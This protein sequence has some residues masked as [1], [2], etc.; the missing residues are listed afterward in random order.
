MNESPSLKDDHKEDDFKSILNMYKAIEFYIFYL[1]VGFFAFGLAIRGNKL[2]NAHLE[3]LGIVGGVFYYMRKCET[4]DYRGMIHDTFTECW[5]E[6]MIPVFLFSMAQ[7]L[8][9]TSGGMD[10]GVDEDNL[11]KQPLE[12]RKDL[13]E[14]ETLA[15]SK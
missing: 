13:E 3:L 11:H 2:K 7:A 9:G 12:E 8:V 5:L 4:R 15:K 1:H 10:Q 6:Y 14:M